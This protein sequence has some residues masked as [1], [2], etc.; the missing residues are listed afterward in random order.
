[1]HVRGR[2]FTSP[3]SLSIYLLATVVPIGIDLMDLDRK[4]KNMDYFNGI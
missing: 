4:P 1:M 3:C 2:R